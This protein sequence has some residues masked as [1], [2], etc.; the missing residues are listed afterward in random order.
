[1]NFKDCHIGCCFIVHH[2]FFWSSPSLSNLFRLLPYV[3]RWLCVRSEKMETSLCELIT[4]LA[5]MISQM[6]LAFACLLLCA[7]CNLCTVCLCGE[8]AHEVQ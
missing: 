8:G 4:T 6:C 3:C 2:Y 5:L 1:M 7:C